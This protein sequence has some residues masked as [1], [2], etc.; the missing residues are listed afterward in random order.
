[1]PESLGAMQLGLHKPF[2]ALFWRERLLS[3]IGGLMVTL[4]PLTSVEYSEIRKSIIDEVACMFVEIGRAD[5]SN[6]RKLAETEQDEV[7]P[8][9]TNTKDHYLYSIRSNDNSKCGYIWFGKEK[10]AYGDVAFVFDVHVYNEYR[11]KGLGFETMQVLEEKVKVLGFNTIE[12]ATLI[13]NKIARNLYEK[14][15]YIRIRGN[16]KV[17][18]MQKKIM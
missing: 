8:N 4:V 9:G 14:C 6:A 12:L 17:I 7:L 1:M 2:I 11:S 10:R 13:S 15:G 18:T 3:D 5:N 16:D